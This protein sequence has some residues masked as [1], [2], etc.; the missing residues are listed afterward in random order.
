MTCTNSYFIMTVDVDPPF[1]SKQNYIIYKGIDQL[2]NLF[3]KYSIRATFFVPAIVAKEFSEVVKKI[4]ELKH[5]IGCHGLK[6]DPME[7]ILS[8]NKQVRNIKKATEI[9]E[10]A[11]GVRPIGFRAPLF[12]INRD[13][14]IALQ[15]N[16]YL[17]DSS[18]VNSLFYARSTIA[19]RSKP[20]CIKNFAGE[21]HPLIEIPVSV[22]PLLPFPIGGGW[23]RIFGLKWAKIGLKMNLTLRKQ[24]MF[25]IHPKD[26][27]SLSGHNLPWY[28]YRNVPNCIKML[29]EVI[30]YVQ[31]N[32][33]LSI[34]ASELA[35]NV[36][37]NFLF[38]K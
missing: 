3:S 33:A 7:T 22:N 31:Q 38:K 21:D 32:G 15:K 34:T 10:F 1:T 24:A 29:T 14:F 12:K 18:I 37:K 9:I 25:Y 11:T 4:V 6:H 26:L 17:Y 30:K 20:F 13:C 27:I 35:S 16:G 2:L 23:L 36:F 5:E 28:Y 8:I 19:W